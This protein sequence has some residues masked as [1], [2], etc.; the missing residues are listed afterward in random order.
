MLAR[1]SHVCRDPS[2]TPSKD[3]PEKPRAP[4]SVWEQIIGPSAA[5]GVPVP[6]RRGHRPARRGPVARSQRTVVKR[7]ERRGLYT[8]QEGSLDTLFKEEDNCL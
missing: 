4:S 1:P 6:H 3:S 8:H 5:D 7:Q 2:P